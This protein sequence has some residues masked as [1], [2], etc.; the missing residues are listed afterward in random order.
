MTGPL[1]SI[2][3]Q[4]VLSPSDFRRISELARER[5]GLNLP[6][7]K[8]GL[9]A[10][11]LGKKIRQG[12]FA[13]FADYYHHVVSDPTGTAL[14]ELID[15][16]TTN[17]TFFLRERAHF[18]FL[19]Q[20]VTGEYQNRSALRIW[21][22]A[23][24]TGE[25]PYSI[26]MYLTDVSQQTACRWSSGVQI[27]AT[28]ISTRVLGKA[29]RAVYDAERF[30][31]I[32]EHWWKSYLLHGQKTCSGTYKVKPAVANLVEFER[33]NLI[34]P[35]PRRSFEIIFCRNVLMYF[36]KPTQKDIVLR[37]LNCLEPGGYLFVGHSETLTGIEHK[38]EYVRPA[39][40]RNHNAPG[41][42]RRSA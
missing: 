4:P 36:D 2:A 12:H 35:L 22:A 30:R 16:L 31:E 24:S 11:R 10:A 39:V 38:L 32:P 26:A 3:D 7:G 6:A 42:R 28:D 1:V 29:Q 13:S 40:Y 27:L 21:S 19:G 5:F 20:L 17:H 15:A 18:D 9:V 37:L 14:I 8:E 25:E 23:C 33:L 41:L 34:E